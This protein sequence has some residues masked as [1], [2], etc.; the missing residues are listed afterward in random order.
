MR[1]VSVTLFHYI[2]L[3][4]LIHHIVLKQS[5]LHRV[6]RHSDFFTSLQFYPECEMFPE[7]FLTSLPDVVFF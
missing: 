3:Y 5:V 7:V 2:I 6:I 1:V 4:Y